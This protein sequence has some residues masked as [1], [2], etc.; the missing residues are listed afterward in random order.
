[1]RS[2]LSDWL[3]HFVHPWDADND[4]RV[5]DE[6]FET[7]EHIRKLRPE[8]HAYWDDADRE[9]VM[10]QESDSFSVLLKILQEGHLRAGWSFR[11]RRPTIYGPSPAVCFTEMP[12]HSFLSYAAEA[13]KRGTVDHYGI[14]LL[15]REV[16][17]AGG[18][19][20]IYGLTEEHAELDGRWPRCLDPSC[21]IGSHEQ[22]RYVATGMAMDR[23]LDWTHEREWRWAD[24]K[25]KCF[26]PGLPILLENEPIQFSRV[27]IIVPSEEEAQ[28]VL[29][30]L[31]AL[32][33]SGYGPWDI[34]YSK[35]VLANTR[36]IPLDSLS[37]NLDSNQM[38]NIRVEDVPD[39]LKLELTRPVPTEEFLG[40][41]REA[42]GQARSAAVTAAAEW[43][44]SNGRGDVYGFS[45]VMLSDP[46]SL[47]ASALIHL[48]L[49]KSFG[50]R[51]YYIMPLSLIG[52]TRMLGEAEAAAD[53]ALEVLYRLLPENSFWIKTVWD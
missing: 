28:S 53:A 40:V 9:F 35:Q 20:V 18:R 27:V 21:G 19:P 13:K 48:G 37:K 34:E 23:K 39:G 42:I 46:R 12:L 47:V 7:P 22:Y 8:H 30:Q 5:S 49:I 1:M 52:E 50:K 45:Y 44:A 31:Y 36:V 43:A 51:D 14:A 29:D 24:H 25:G 4:P 32:H 15:R 33:D 6:G 41:T 38:V 17:K 11:N 10:Y 26:V 3:I 2:D 16:F